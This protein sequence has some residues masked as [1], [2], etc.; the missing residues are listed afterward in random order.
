M[1][2]IMKNIKRIFLAL[3]L[4]NV[5]S[6]LPWHRGYGYGY[7]GGRAAAIGIG[8]LAAGVAVGSAI[9]HRHRDDDSYY[10]GKYRGQRQERRE[11]IEDYDQQ[12]SEKRAELRRINPN[13]TR[14]QEL[15]GQINLLEQLRNQA[16]S[17]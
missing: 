11:T 16:Y 13:S 8:S 2:V 9:G 5:S 1:E 7:G 6:L 14:A 15:R 12:L 4:L 17:S 10:T 3:T